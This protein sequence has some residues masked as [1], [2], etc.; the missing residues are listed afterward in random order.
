MVKAVGHDLEHRFL[1]VE[2]TA[3]LVDVAEL[4]RLAEAQ[5][6]GVG[7]LLADDHAEQRGLADAVRADDADDAAARERERD[8]LH[9]GFAL[10]TLVEVRGLDDDVAQ[11]RTRRD[12]DLFEVELAGLL[13][14]GRHLFVAL[15]TGLAL[16][17]PATGVLAHP[18]EFLAQSPL[19]LLVL[20]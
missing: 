12:L 17:L 16:G 20:L 18:L 8:V 6:A 4:D 15:Q 19:E 14:F 5:L 2:A 7:L 10:E 11:A 9:Q 13:G 3:A 1:G